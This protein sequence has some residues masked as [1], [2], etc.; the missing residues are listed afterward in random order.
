MKRILVVKLRPL[1]D[2]VVA[3]PKFE[4][5][6]EAFPKAWITALVQPPAQELLQKTGWANEVFAY[7]RNR[8]DQRNFVSRAWKHVQL[9]RALQK[10]HYDLAIDFSAAHRSAQ[11]I[12]WSGAGLKLGL[13]LPRLKGLYDLA[14]SGEGERQTSAMDLDSRVLGLLGLEAKSYDRPGGFWPV[15][16]EA[17]RF[18]DTFWKANRFEDQDLVIAVN[19]F[20][21]CPSK[22]WYPEKW[23]AVIQELLGNG[24]KVFFTCAPLEKNG[25]KPIE[26]KVGKILPVYAG[27]PLTPLLGLYQKSRAV[28]SVDSGP[29]HIAAAA[30]A[31]TV[32]I[33]GPEPVS[34]WHPYSRERHPLVLREIDCRPCGLS[35]CVERKHECMTS[36]QPAEVIKT[37]KALLRNTLGPATVA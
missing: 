26:D 8:I 35:V 15:P 33:W 36:L 10:R 27:S 3:G 28:L 25:L 14:A 30:G 21:S 11:I 9:V 31:P 1:G 23:A 24:F 32:T 22:E 34:R 12:Q 29:R 37:L 2:V 5:I 7:H 20:A 6:R 13:G 19:P 4:A 17:S 18:A 16:K